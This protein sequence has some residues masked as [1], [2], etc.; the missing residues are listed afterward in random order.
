MKNYR[1]NL[2]VGKFYHIFNH[3]VSNR[4][5]FKNEENFEFFLTKCSKYISPITTTYA[6]CL[7]PNHFHFLIQINEAYQDGSPISNPS[8]HFKDL[9]S[10]YTQAFNKFNGE[11]G[12]LF[13]PRFK[14]RLIGSKKDLR[15]TLLYIHL[16]PLKHKLV[17]QLLEWKHS[18]YN[19]ILNNQE[20][21]VKREEAIQLF[22]DLENFIY[23]HKQQIAM[24]NYDF[25]FGDLD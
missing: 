13:E 23:V 12:S 20:S 1:V 19:D 6:Y 22:D 15:N 7:I 9:F 16:N 10:S 21:L 2:E 8:K 3:A 5:L 14:R 11:R 18:S 4:R 17:K 24:K 25:G